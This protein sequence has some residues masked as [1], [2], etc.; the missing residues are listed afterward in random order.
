[1]KFKLKDDVIDII[2]DFK[3]MIIAR[4]EYLFEDSTYRIQPKFDKYQNNEPKW[5]AEGRLELK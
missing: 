1:M 4:A 3:G 2:S 5:I